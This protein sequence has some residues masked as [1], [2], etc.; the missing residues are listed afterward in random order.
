MALVGR[1]ERAGEQNHSFGQWRCGVRKMNTSALL[2][3][4]ILPGIRCEGL[5]GYR[6]LLIV[7]PISQATVRLA[8]ID[9]AALGKRNQQ[10]LRDE[11]FL[12][13][14][15]P[16]P[17]VQFDGNRSSFRKCLHGDVHLAACKGV[18]TFSTVAR[19]LW[20]TCT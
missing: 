14:T 1:I 11:T 5:A 6:P 7:E 16:P 8:H 9:S 3:K 17:V 18:G 2:K 19:L 4:Q 20:R 10:H 13:V 15:S 12:L